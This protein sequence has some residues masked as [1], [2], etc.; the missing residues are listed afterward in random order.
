MD[1]RKKHMNRW[2]L[3]LLN[4]VVRQHSVFNLINRSAAMISDGFE[5]TPNQQGTSNM[6]ALNPSLATLAG[7]N[8]R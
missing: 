7:F 5:T 4:Q 1:L 2:M 3:E 8:T 6:I